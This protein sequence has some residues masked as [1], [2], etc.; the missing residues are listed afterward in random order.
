MLK[1]VG[2]S[3]CGKSKGVQ[4]SR[5]SSGVGARGGKEEHKENMKKGG[6]RRERRQ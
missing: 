1:Q 3:G 5:V 4:Y 2:E 6:R